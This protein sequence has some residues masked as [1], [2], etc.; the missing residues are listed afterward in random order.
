QGHPRIT[1]I[2]AIN[3]YDYYGGRGLARS[4]MLGSFISTSASIP[5]IGE[6]VMAMRNQFII[7]NVLLGGVTDDGDF[8]EALLDHL[9]QIN[10]RAGYS[11]MFLTLLR[12]GESWVDDK[13][14]YSDTY[15]PAL[16]LW[17]SD[18]WASEDERKESTISMPG[19]EVRTIPNVGHFM[20]V[21][22]PDAIIDAVN[23]VNEKQTIGAKA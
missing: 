6:A 2:V 1:A 5:V 20:T 17:G 11:N 16:V 23:A 12:N 7:D 4:S 10:N 19:A 9:Y 22:Q 18:D 15:I 21:D 3:P 14:L 8:P 13:S